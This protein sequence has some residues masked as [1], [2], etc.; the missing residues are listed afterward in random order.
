MLTIIQIPVLTDNYIYLIHEPV[1][2]ET[3]VVDPALAQ[4]VLDVLDDKGWRLT[5]IL[6]THH[7]WD[8]V[9]GNL[10]L[11][12]KT[13]CTV[14]APQSDRDR[15]PGIER[16]V[17]EDDVITLGAYPARVISTP[18]HTSGHIVYYFA[19]DKVLFCG[20]TLFAMGCGRLF[21]GSAEQMWN[22][23]QKL[24]TLPSSTR[25][26]CTHEYTQTNG[27]F[28]LSVEPDNLQLQQRM[29]LV[30]Q[31]REKHLATV[32]STI[33]EELATNPFFRENS[34]ALQATIN[35]KNRTPIEVFAEI[36]RLKDKF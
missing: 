7:H 31:L 22:S 23:L 13:G 25:V 35:M 30:N 15:I 34:P 3:G 16:G 4:P 26:Y 28:A 27:R 1:S 20:D 17:A 24:K 14:I 18:G 33:E 12:Q 2:G 36:R 19:E 6:N 5:Y 32:P 8:H 11:K 21:E 10:E 9:G 29:E